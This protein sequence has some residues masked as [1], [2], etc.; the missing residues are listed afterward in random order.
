MYLEQAGLFD[1]V[2]TTTIGVNGKGTQ[3]VLNR[4]GMYLGE[5]YSDAP[6]SDHGEFRVCQSPADG[7]HHPLSPSGSWNYVL[8]TPSLDLLAPVTSKGGEHVRC[9]EHDENRRKG[10]KFSIGFEPITALRIHTISLSRGLAAASTLAERYNPTTGP[11]PVAQ[12]LFC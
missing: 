5:G 7:H 8:Q 10:R 11:L 2:F 12:H 3:T 9:E 4:Q 1:A 6:P